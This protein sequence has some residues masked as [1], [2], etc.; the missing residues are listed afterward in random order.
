MGRTPVRS[1]FWTFGLRSFLGH[2][3]PDRAGARPASNVGSREVTW[4]PPVHH[5][6][7]W[8][9]R[10]SPFTSHFSPLNPLLSRGGSGVFLDQRDQVVGGILDGGN[11]CLG[12]RLIRGEFLAHVV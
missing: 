7:P 10:L 9:G 2:A 12:E 6:G 1:S 8:A 3:T 5:P 11:V 4:S